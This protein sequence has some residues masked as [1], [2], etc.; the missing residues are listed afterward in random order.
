VPSAFLW[1]LADEQSGRAAVWQGLDEGLAEGLY[2][3]LWRSE[4]GANERESGE[5][6]LGLR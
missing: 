5:K 3:R 4:I 2:E 1:W 6:K